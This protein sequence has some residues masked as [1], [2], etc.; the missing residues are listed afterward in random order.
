MAVVFSVGASS[1]QALQVTGFSD[2]NVASWDP[3]ANSVF[4]A[5][6]VHQVRFNIPWNA[7]LDAGQVAEW[8][9]KI[10]AAQ[11]KG[12]QV[13]VSF[14]RAGAPP[15][16]LD[17]R[18]AIDTFRRQFPTVTE[19]TAWNEPNHNANSSDQNPY[20]DATTAAK[21][22]NQLDD[23]CGLGT[24]CTVA[25]GDFSDFNSLTTY[26]DTYRAALHRTPDV[27][28]VHAYRA[29]NPTSTGAAP[30]P[31]KLGSWVSRYTDGKP[32]W[33][34]E[35]GAYYCTTA[36]GTPAAAAA[37]QNAAAANLNALMAASGFSSVGRVY[38]YFLAVASG[39]GAR[40]PNIEDDPGLIGSGDAIRPALF[41]LFPNVPA[42]VAP[43]STTG[44]ASDI[45]GVGATIRGTVNPNGWATS[46]H[47]E[48]GTTTSYGAS[49]PVPVASVGSGGLRLPSATRCR[50]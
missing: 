36:N 3:V 26:V 15:L 9:T 49:I 14:D 44:L 39:G 10:G 1:A 47:F 28:A 21:Y 12:A 38:Y 6:G 35:V 22:W 45:S 41:T 30:D 50:T 40:C 13:L 42:G 37:V 33:I 20:R 16:P 46:Y 18:Y 43:S 27:W 7:S 24:R 8:T 19:F 32:V 23:A 48:Y 17:Y 11:A 34:T 31:G 29:I 4:N 25:A 2:Q 5:T